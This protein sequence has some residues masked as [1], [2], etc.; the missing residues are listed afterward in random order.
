[1]VMLAGVPLLAPQPARAQDGRALAA[2]GPDHERLDALIGKWTT[3]IKLWKTP[4]SEPVALKGT[5]MRQWTLGGRFVE[6]HAE[7]ETSRGGSFK[8]VAYLGF[9]RRTE[10]YERF[11]ITDTSTGIFTERGRYDPDANL[12]RTQGS[13]VDP[14]SGVVILTT[15]ELKIESPSRHVF[16]AYVTGA[17]GVRWKQL[18]IVYSKE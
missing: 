15:S 13:E 1:M 6:E 2:P 3:A 16:T 14:A 5:A 17:S 12:I 9:N 8:S 18:E 10:L 11:W 4:E 7:N